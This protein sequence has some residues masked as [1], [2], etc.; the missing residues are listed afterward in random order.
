VLSPPPSSGVGVGLGVGL[1]L[2]LLACAALGI[3]CEPD[4]PVCGPEQG[5]VAQV[6]DGDTIRLESGERI[7]YLLIDTPEVTEPV[8]CFGPEATEL[9]RSL[10]EGKTVQLTY[11]QECT[12]RYDRLL[13]YVDLEGRSI[14][15]L[16]LERG[17]ACVLHIRPN[18]ASRVDE[19]R[20]LEEQ[21]EVA[22][23]GMWGACAD[24]PCD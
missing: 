10:V 16:L 6:I 17:Y 23:A 18:G 24:D 1:G 19:Y 20:Q 4:G 8:E 13:A 5:V 9:N 21:A 2:T 3:A 12:D 15:E 11:D 7:R 22:M 14:N